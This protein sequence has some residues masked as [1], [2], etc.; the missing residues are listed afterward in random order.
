MPMLSLTANLGLVL[1]LFLV[2]LEVD[3]RLLFAN[4]KVALS[5]GLAGMILPFGMGAAV[6]YGLYHQFGHETGDD[7]VSFGIFLLFIGVAMAITV[8]EKRSLFSFKPF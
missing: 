8:R 5:V 4:Y 6:A 2:G 3:M 7:R 1:F